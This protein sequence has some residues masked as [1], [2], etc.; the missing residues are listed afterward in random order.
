M[1]LHIGCG[2]NKLEGF[3]NIDKAKE[4]EPDKVVNIEEGLPF[5]DNSFDYIYSEHCIEHVRPYYWKFVL[6]EIARVAKE[7]CILEL[8]LPFDNI[9]SRTNPDH[10][11]GFSWGSFRQLEIGNAGKR[12]Y[13]SKLNLIRLS[14]EPNKLIKL[15]YYMFPVLYRGDV[16]FKFKIVK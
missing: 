6:D 15:F 2:Y 1:K 12:N 14:S 13:Y 9:Q 3:I 10:Y 5:P 11:R 7:G 16:Y 8:R 4:V